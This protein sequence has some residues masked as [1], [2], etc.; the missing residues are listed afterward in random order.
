MES[1]L[2]QNSKPLTSFSLPRRSAPAPQTHTTAAPSTPLQNE[3]LG[4]GLSRHSTGEEQARPRRPVT[5]VQPGGHR[6]RLRTAD[7]SLQT[8]PTATAPQRR[9]TGPRT[10]TPGRFLFFRAT[11][12]APPGGQCPRGGSSSASPGPWHLLAGRLQRVG[13]TT[14]AFP[15]RCG[16][17]CR[18][19]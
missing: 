19:G 16:R 8:W 13:S 15:V 5:L 10:S 3:R 12:T 9:E 4:P 1:A 14:A 6:Q 7:R 11:V 18:D 2:T 17:A